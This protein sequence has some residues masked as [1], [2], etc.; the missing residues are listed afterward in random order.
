MRLLHDQVFASHAIGAH[1]T[2]RHQRSQDQLRSMVCHLSG[3]APN[4]ACPASESFHTEVRS[5]GIDPVHLICWNLEL[6]EA[7]D[8][9]IPHYGSLRS[10]DQRPTTVRLQ[11]WEL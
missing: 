11:V 4:R 6:A 9:N 3:L 10:V 8:W 1:L 7:I 5:P 2:E